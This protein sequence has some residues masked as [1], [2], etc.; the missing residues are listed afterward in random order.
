MK[1]KGNGKAKVDRAMKGKDPEAKGKLVSS[2]EVRSKV[3]AR[4]LLRGRTGI[5][6]EKVFY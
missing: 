2:K 1:R 5:L 6:E 4:L 3:G